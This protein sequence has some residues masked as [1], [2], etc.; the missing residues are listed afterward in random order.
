LLGSYRDQPLGSFGRFSAVSFHETKNISS[1]EGG[2]LSIN[3]QADVDRAWTIYDKGTN[4]RAFLGG[5]VD[6]Y[7]W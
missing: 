4:R 2:A 1:G 7:A 6:K 5:R 3:D